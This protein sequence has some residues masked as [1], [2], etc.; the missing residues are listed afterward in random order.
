MQDRKNGMQEAEDREVAEQSARISEYV[1]EWYEGPPH[2]RLIALASAK[3]MSQ[4]LYALAKLRVADLIA[5]GCDRV[6]GLAEAH[7]DRLARLLRAAAALGLIRSAAPGQFALAELGDLLRAGRPDG[8]RDF[9]L[10]MGD[11]AMWQP[12][13]RLDESVRTGVPG[14]ELVHG[15][16]LFSDLARRP[17]LADLYQRA[18]APFAAELGAELASSYDFADVRH[19]VDVGGGTGLFLI[20]LLRAH[21][22]L[23]GTLIDRPEALT[24]ARPIVESSGLGGRLQ[25]RAGELPDPPEVAADCF[26]LKNV[27]HCFDDETSSAALHGLRAVMPPGARLLVIETI[28]G[29]GDD[30]DWGKLIDI[31]VMCTTGGRERTSQEWSALLG[32]SGFGISGIT[33]ATPPQWVIEAFSR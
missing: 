11:E 12:F 3:W 33:P 23:S 19:V 25:L 14:Y 22:H 6:A 16:P 10:Y 15:A 17:L 24:V 32:D 31:E 20:M 2:V 9:V 26:V 7:P 1:P 28:P 18:W 21:T 5:G 4:C 30:F 29:D 13:A 27:L 8:L